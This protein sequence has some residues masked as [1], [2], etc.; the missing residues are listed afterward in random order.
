MNSQIALE[1]LT[2]AICYNNGKI[3]TT[4]LEQIMISLIEPSQRSLWSKIIKI[5]LKAPEYADP[6]FALRKID[7]MY[8][9][10]LTLCDMKTHKI[11]WQ[12]KNN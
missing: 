2:R 5:S 6:V 7:N 10:I 1:K 3:A 8:H 4:Q 11:I 12:L 9:Q